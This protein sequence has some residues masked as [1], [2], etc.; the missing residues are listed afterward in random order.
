[1][2]KNEILL[3]VW[4]N[5]DEFAKRHN[6]DL[7]EMVATLQ[8]MERHPWSAIVDR[9]KENPNQ[10]LQR[11]AEKSAAAELNRSTNNNK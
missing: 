7:N 1:M 3:E 11:T 2:N 9:R 10:S 4:H 8:D 5:R 6:Y